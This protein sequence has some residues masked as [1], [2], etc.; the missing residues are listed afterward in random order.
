MIKTKSHLI[1]AADSLQLVLQSVYSIA[2]NFTIPLPNPLS[3]PDPD[4]G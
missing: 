2:I 1:S 4:A 3:W